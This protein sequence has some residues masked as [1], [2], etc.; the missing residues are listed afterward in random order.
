ML[1]QFIN[2]KHASRSLQL[3][4]DDKRKE[5]LN[6]VADA[7]DR[8]IP[9]LLAANAQDLARMDKANPMFDRLLLTADRLK[10][11][12]LPSHSRSPEQQSGV[13]VVRDTC[14]YHPA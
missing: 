3:M 1:Q 14:K 8:E 4:T 7:I 11:A 12:Y 6:A 9:T 10:V 13:K 5:I 2:A